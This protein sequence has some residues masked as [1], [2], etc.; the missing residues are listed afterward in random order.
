[1]LDYCGNE[2]PDWEQGYD[3]ML[4]TIYRSSA[5]IVIF[6]I[7]DLLGY[8]SDTRLNTPGRAE[9]NWSYRITKE[10]LNL[11]DKEKFKKYNSLYNR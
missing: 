5:G 11:I 2:N 7:Q 4:K 9:G 10:Q 1:M 8:G 6:P 3:A